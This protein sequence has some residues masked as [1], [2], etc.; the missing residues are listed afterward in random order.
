MFEDG[1]SEI[2]AKAMLGRHRLTSV[3]IPESVKRIGDWAFAGCSHLERVKMPPCELGKGVFR[4]CG[5]LKCLDIGRGED[6]A[7]LLAEAARWDVQYLVEPGTAGSREWFALWDSWLFRFLEE[8]D[9]EGYSGQ[10]PCGEE[11]FGTSDAAA[12]ESGRRREKARRCLLRLMHAE[13]LGEAEKKRLQNYVSEHTAGSPAGEEA[14][15]LILERYAEEEAW[16]AAFAEAG[17]VNEDNLEQILEEIPESANRMKSFFLRRE[18]GGRDP[19]AMLG[20]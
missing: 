6:T 2:P 13:S 20:I 8:E 16:Y 11:D 5:A 1:I 9:A 18:G 17:G 3:E 12:Y 7:A 15:K 14:W 19:F 10:V 4:D